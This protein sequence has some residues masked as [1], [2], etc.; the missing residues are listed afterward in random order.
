MKKVTIT[1]EGRDDIELEFKDDE[2]I[3]MYIRLND[4]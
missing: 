4:N 3:L 2:M 1:V